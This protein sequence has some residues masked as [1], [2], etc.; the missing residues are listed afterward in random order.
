MV[1]EDKLYKGEDGAALRFYWDTDRNNFLSEKLGK[2]TYD[3]VLYLEIITPGSRESI[4][5]YEIIRRYA[6][7]SEVAETRNVSVAERFKSQL[8][9]FLNDDAGD[10]DVTG[11]A[12]TAA[13]FLD[14]ATI[15]SLYEGKVFTL[16]ALAALPDEK[17]RVLG[18]GGRTTR[19]Q[20]R[21]FLEA[22]KGGEATAALVQDL[23]NLKEQLEQTNA[24]AAAAEAR[25]KELEEKTGIEAPTATPITV[26]VEPAP[27]AE[28]GAELI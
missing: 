12:L 22:A 5:V 20:A 10:K 25:V 21:A 6:D 9:A 1:P 3:N 8:E 4:P 2:P 14:K 18:M 7:G 13:P 27:V 19:D 16:E 15:A 24:R 26:P 23:A 28:P 17:L 11:T